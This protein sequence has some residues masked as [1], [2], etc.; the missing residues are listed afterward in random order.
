M[1][2]MDPTTSH[3]GLPIDT[4]KLSFESVSIRRRI[5]AA[6]WLVVA[7]AI[8]LWWRATSIDRLSLPEAKVLDLGRRE[9]QFPVRVELESRVSSHPVDIVKREV[10]QLISNDL[11]ESDGISVDLSSGNEDACTRLC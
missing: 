3:S 2:T 11:Q 9:W 7:L 5:L 1:T 4:A 6:Y 8:P 10:A